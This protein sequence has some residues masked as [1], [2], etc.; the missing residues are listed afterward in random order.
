MGLSQLSLLETLIQIPI[1]HPTQQ[2]GFLNEYRVLHL[3]YLE[4][5][6]SSHV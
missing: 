5:Y 3:V 6:C 2:A 4:G 1:E